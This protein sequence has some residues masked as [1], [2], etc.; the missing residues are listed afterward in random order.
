MEEA[1]YQT[2]KEVLL[3]HSRS[4]WT[5]Q[6]DDEAELKSTLLLL[7]QEHHLTTQALLSHSGAVAV[8]LH[9]A[10]HVPILTAF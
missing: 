8:A 10:L 4:T 1:A 7:W 3:L 5:A 2:V 6:V 9:K